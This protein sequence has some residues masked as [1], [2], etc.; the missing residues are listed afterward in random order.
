MPTRPLVAVTGRRLEADDLAWT[1]NAYASPQNYADALARAGA[2]PMV[3]PPVRAGSAAEWL[4]GVDGLVLSGGGDVDPA[5]YG[6]EPHPQEYGV[7]SDVDQFE[8]DLL[9]A[10]LDRGLPVL[11]V[12]RGA[13]LLNVAFGGTLHQHLAATGGLLDHGVPSTRKPSHHRVRIVAGSQ[14]AAALGVEAATVA[15]IH[16]QAIDIVADELTVT[17][18]APDG[19]VEAIEPREPGSAWVVGV[20]W[21]P[22]WT[23]DRDPIQQRLFDCFVAE[24]RDRRAESLPLT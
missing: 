24:A 8:L 22:E 23:A 17:A 6:K 14:L 19:M 20:Q 11:A 21:H 9:G 16:H 12:C 3:V 1:R 2:R 10:A 18:R 13:Q 5:R 4:D 7:E 15:S